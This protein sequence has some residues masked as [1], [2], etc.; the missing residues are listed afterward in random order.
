MSNSPFL[1]FGKHSRQLLSLKAPHHMLLPAID[2]PQLQISSNYRSKSKAPA[3]DVYSPQ[4][5]TFSH[6]KRYDVDTKSQ[7]FQGYVVTR[8]PILRYD[9]LQQTILT[10]TYWWHHL[11]SN[12]RNLFILLCSYLLNTKFVQL[13]NAFNFRLLQC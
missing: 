5:S 4:K 8:C 11:L 7:I 3:N 2:A 6:E 9:V 13:Q 1:N 10:T 12:G